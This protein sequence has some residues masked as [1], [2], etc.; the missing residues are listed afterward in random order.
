MLASSRTHTHCRLYH[1]HPDSPRRDLAFPTLIPHGP[2]WAGSTLQRQGWSHDPAELWGHC[3]VYILQTGVQ[4]GT[5]EQA[6]KERGCGHLGSE[7]LQGAETRAVPAP[8][9][10]GA[11]MISASGL[12]PASPSHARRLFLFIPCLG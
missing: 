6:S 7:E 4:I 9:F 3:R 12:T 1:Q 8:L 11:F 2:H 5:A 10:I